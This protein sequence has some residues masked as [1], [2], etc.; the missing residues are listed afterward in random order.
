MSFFQLPAVK[1]DTIFGAAK[2][3]LGPSYFVTALE[4]IESSFLA[5]CIA[6]ILSTLAWGWGYHYFYVHFAS[7]DIVP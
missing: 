7:L 5:T 1:T 4:W 2:T 6:Y 3:K